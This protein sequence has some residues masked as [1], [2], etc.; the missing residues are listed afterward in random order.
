MCWGVL[1]LNVFVYWTGYYCFSIAYILNLPI[2]YLYIPS[3]LIPNYLAILILF[4]LASYIYQLL[5]VQWIHI[6]KQMS[7]IG[8]WGMAG[9]LCQTT[10]KQYDN[11]HVTGDAGSLLQVWLSL[12]SF[13]N[14]FHF[15]R[16]TSLWFVF[17]LQMDLWLKCVKYL[18]IEIQRRPS[19]KHSQRAQFGRLRLKI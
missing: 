18:T 14:L 9:D 19:S 2:Q 5:M 13:K 8:L 11:M 12:Y 15:F 6:G 16:C 10:P 1:L 3:S 4:Y 7:F 17:S